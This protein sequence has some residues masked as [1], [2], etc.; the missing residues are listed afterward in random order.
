MRLA[1]VIALS[2]FALVFPVSSAEAAIT[3]RAGTSIDLSDDEAPGDGIQAIAVANLDSVAGADLIVV[4]PDYGDV[5]V[6][7]NDG[8]GNFSLHARL[9]SDLSPIAVTTGNFDNESGV[10]MAVLNDDDTV[11]TYVGDGTGNFNERGN[12]EVCVDDPGAVGVVAANFDGI[13]H[14]FDDLAVLCDSTVYLLKG[15]GDGT[16]STFS[17]S[18]VSTGKF[19]SGGFAI[20]AGRINTAHNY[21]DLAVSS[22]GSNSVSVLFGNNDGTFQ[23][24]RVIQ[25]GL[26]QPQGLA[27]GEFDVDSNN[28]PDIAV[29]SGIDTQATV[30]ILFGDG[31][32]NFTVEDTKSTQSAEIGSV[33]MVAL[34]LDGD[35]KKDLAVGSLGESGGVA[36]EVQLFCQQ[37]ST[38]CLDTG[39]HASATA[40]NFQIQGNVALTGTVSALQSG[41]LNGDGRPDLVAVEVDTDS[42]KILLNTTGTVQP[43]TPPTSPGT[44]TPPLGT[45]TPTGPTPTRTPTFTPQ[46]TATPTLIPQPYGVCNIPLPTATAASKPVA[47]VT[48][49]FNHDGRQDV[50]V[51][52]AANDRIVLLES[53]TGQALGG[54]KCVAAGLTTQTD[55]AAVANPVALATGSFNNDQYVDLAVAGSGGLTIYLGNGQGGFNLD[56]TYDLADQDSQGGPMPRRLAV[57]HINQDQWKDVLVTSWASNQVSLFLGKTD[58]SGGFCNV[59]PIQVGMRTSSVI[60]QDLNDDGLPDFA[61]AGDQP[62]VAIFLQVQGNQT[63]T[64][65]GTPMPTATAGICPPCPTFKAGSTLSLP[66]FP[67]GLVADLFDLSDTVPD[68]AVALSAE[69]SSTP[70]PGASATPTP[71]SVASGE[72]TIFIGKATGGRVI[73]DRQNPIAV[74]RDSSGPD[75]PSA[76]SAMIAAK[77]NPNAFCPPAARCDLALTDAKNND[78]VIF[79]ASGGGSF[80]VV[81]PIRVGAAP[82]DLA[83]ADIDTDGK[84]DIVTANSGDGSISVLLSSEQPP[85]PTPQPTFTPTNTPAP[86]T[87][88]ATPTAILPPSPTGTRTP[89]PTTVPTFTPTETPRGVMHLQGSCAVVPTW[90]GRGGPWV[91]LAVAALLHALR[92]TGSGQKQ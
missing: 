31:A 75:L 36:G 48:G 46:P 22:T 92:R 85:T 87:A 41:D 66:Q 19:S 91:L 42:I 32:G 51:A 77:L 68:L 44:P 67:T 86:P 59:C 70:L 71:A 34:D 18:S 72:L 11:T 35:L 12:Y 74:P 73:F 15:V 40:A 8:K 60:V 13:D 61:V 37:Q 20:A 63:P 47:V 24:A 38:V 14:A 84:L 9:S 69:L 81:P 1:V 2:S 80:S 76:P 78:V 89:R 4:H 26:S 62:E 82:V 52:D 7:L 56:H 27:I 17:T 43:T 64:P 25:S 53:G 83:S 55:I 6:F 90:P 23:S 45:P 54:D 10:D 28:N 3:F 49:D 30:M 65:T 50:A 29:I 16:F 21:V 58:G 5:S 39:G 57:A 88:T 79:Y 33:A